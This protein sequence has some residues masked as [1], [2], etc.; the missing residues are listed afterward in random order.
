MRDEDKW[1]YNETIAE[2]VERLI[3][4]ALIDLAVQHIKRMT[5]HIKRSNQNGI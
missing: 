1:V 5:Q 4:D 2:M 3:D